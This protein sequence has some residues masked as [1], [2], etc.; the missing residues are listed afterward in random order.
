MQ[1]DSVLSLLEVARTNASKIE[2][3]SLLSSRPVPGYCACAGCG[4]RISTTK[5]Y[6]LAC[7]MDRDRSQE[8]GA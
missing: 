7:K 8:P 2:T 5:E 1:T 3:L 4:K 6:C